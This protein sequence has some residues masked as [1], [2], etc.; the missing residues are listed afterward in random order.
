[1]ATPQPI[2]N[3]QRS[4]EVFEK[5]HDMECT[6]GARGEVERGQGWCHARR[7]CQ[8]LS[9]SPFPRPAPRVTSEALP[10]CILRRMATAAHGTGPYGCRAVRGGGLVGSAWGRTAVCRSDTAATRCCRARDSGSHADL[11]PSL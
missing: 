1:M 3:P 4:Y 7:A 11:H 9:S 2:E 5:K 6:T 8:W 10:Y